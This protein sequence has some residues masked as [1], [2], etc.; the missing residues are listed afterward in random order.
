M[1]RLFHVASSDRSCLSLAMAACWE[2]VNEA[3]LTPCT[4]THDAQAAALSDL[5]SGS[6]AASSIR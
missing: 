1:T 4:R 2:Q 6:S 5:M 3:T